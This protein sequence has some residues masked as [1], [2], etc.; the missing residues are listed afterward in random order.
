MIYREIVPVRKVNDG[1]LAVA[2]PLERAADARVDV[3]RDR[4]R[5]RYGNSD[6]SS[7]PALRPDVVACAV[8]NRL[9]QVRP[10]VGDGVSASADD[11][12]YD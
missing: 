1:A 7:A 8:C 6:E 10:L 4:R 2:Q 12:R 3:V 5:R 9:K 11:L